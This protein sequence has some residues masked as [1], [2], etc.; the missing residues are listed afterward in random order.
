MKNS[1]NLPLWIESSLKILIG[2]IVLYIILIAG[3]SNGIEIP[4][5]LT[6][7]GGLLLFK[8]KFIPGKL[9]L[10]IINIFIS[11][12]ISS[13][14]S[15]NTQLSFYQVWLIGC[16]F[17]LIFIFY[18]LINRFDLRKVLIITI[19]ILGI[20]L[21][22]FS[23]IDAFRWYQIYRLALPDGSLIPSI[24][25]RLNGGNTIAAFYSLI[26]FFYLGIFIDSNKWPIKVFG[27]IAC[28]S[29]VFLLI[30]STSR[31]AFVGLLAGFIFMIIWIYWEKIKSLF[32]I[33][34]INHKFFFISVLIFI[35]ILI[36]GFLLVAWLFNPA[37]NHPSHPYFLLSRSPLWEPAINAFYSSPLIGTGPYTYYS[38]YL[39][40]H[41]VPL[42]H[43]YLHAHNSYLDIL[44]NTGLLGLSVF[45]W[46]VFSFL[47]MIKSEFPSF[48]VKRNYFTIAILAG[49]F[50]FTAHSFF[51]GLYLMIFAGFTFIFMIVLL[52]FKLPLLKINTFYRVSILFL[53]I[54]VIGF[55]WLNYWR[56]EPISRTVNASNQNEIAPAKDA[57]ETALARNPKGVIANLYSAMLFSD[58]DQNI[59]SIA[60]PAMQTAVE[61][62][63]Y[64]GLNHANLAALYSSQGDYT[65]ALIEINSAVEL[66]PKSSIFLL[67]Q[68]LYLEKIQDF[69]NAQEAYQNV[70]S[71]NPD[72]SNAYFWRENPFRE[73]IAA[74]TETSSEIEL[75]GFDQAIQQP[76]ALPMIYSAF[77]ELHLNNLEHAR[78][79]AKLA[80]I[81]YF[82]NTSE[83]I[84]LDWLNAVL[85]YK[86]K[87]IDKA[88]KL[89]E[90]ILIQLQSPGIY[91]PGSAGKSLYYDGVYR[92]PVLAIEFVPQLTIIALPGDWENRVYEISQWY[93]ETGDNAS[94]NRIYDLLLYYSPDYGEFH[95]VETAC[96]GA[97]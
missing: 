76:Y 91:G 26:V 39:I 84:E 40:N 31:G 41:S 64:W 45:T 43:L 62:D 38:W 28:I 65:Q 6:L 66:A 68:G 48:R 90:K 24:S 29:A 56:T 83:R 88:L 15:L 59:I 63:P 92:A 95:K 25:F 93:R 34:K 75:L 81:A 27:I 36:I 74:E 78:S 52:L 79:L 97:N 77:A 96:G 50:S 69:K 30:L 19:S 89:S 16:A 51:D 17:L 20:G 57:I 3:Y 13:L 42:G 2:I 72:W 23:W 82:G 11:S 22:F 37:S 35:V 87:N 46:L 4:I 10:P 5:F 70:L 8:G 54:F 58:T 73:K 9:I 53:I 55:S 60:L 86:A 12:L 18:D 49:I 61:T 33:I 85:L 67:N 44:S 71:I 47:K 94:C 21:M 7:F 32:N 1:F 14:F 80:G